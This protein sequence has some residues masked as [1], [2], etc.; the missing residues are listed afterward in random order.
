MNVWR[1][2]GVVGWTRLVM[3]LHARYIFFT[4]MHVADACLILSLNFCPAWAKGSNCIY[5]RMQDTFRGRVCECPIMKGVKFVGDGYT[6]CEGT[7]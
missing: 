1:T 6:N 5:V 4:T 7:L 2:M 3:L